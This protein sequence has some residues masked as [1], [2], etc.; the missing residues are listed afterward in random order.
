VRLV[1]RT[2]LEPLN[3]HI[4]ATG[5]AANAPAGGVPVRVSEVRSNGS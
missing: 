2:T 3:Q 1:Q 5:V 4:G